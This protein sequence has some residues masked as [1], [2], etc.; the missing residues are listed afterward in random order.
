MKRLFLVGFGYKDYGA[1]YFS[2]YIKEGTGF[3]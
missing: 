3:I 2:G 1:E